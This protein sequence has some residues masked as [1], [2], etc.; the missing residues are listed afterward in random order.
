MQLNDLWEI[1]RGNHFLKEGAIKAKQ[2]E[3][4]LQALMMHT[5]PGTFPIL[6]RRASRRQHAKPESRTLLPRS[7]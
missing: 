4:E 5:F 2:P 6:R 1:P 3:F 7:D